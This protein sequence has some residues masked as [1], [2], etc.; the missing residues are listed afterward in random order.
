MATQAEGDITIRGLNLVASSSLWCLF[1]YKE[2]H[3][4]LSGKTS[5]DE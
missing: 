1:P 4:F 5:S 2:N 3:C